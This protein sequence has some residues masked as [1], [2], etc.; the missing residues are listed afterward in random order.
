VSALDLVNRALGVVG[1]VVRRVEVE[2]TLRALEAQEIRGYSEQRARAV[3]EAEHARR[4]AD[5]GRAEVNRLRV[6][7]FALDELLAGVGHTEKA[8]ACRRLID[9]A[10]GRGEQRAA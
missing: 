9:V 1:L 4:A 8:I 7:L 6:C 3:R 5:A 2:R 10:L